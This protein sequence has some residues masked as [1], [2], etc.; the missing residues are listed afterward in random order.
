MIVLGIDPGATV[1]WAR[2][3]VSRDPVR[4]DIITYQ[5]AGDF[6]SD[7]ADH[8]A[9]KLFANVDIVGLEEAQ[10]AHGVEKF[11]AV[12][13]L[14][15]AR[16]I[17]ERLVTIAETKYGK[18][19]TRMTAARARGIVVGSSSPSD[20]TIKN[21]VLQRIRHWPTRSNAHQRDA[22]L[23]ALAVGQTTPVIRRTGT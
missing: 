15:A 2:L 11:Y 9:A 13:A 20:A 10:V 23:V 8:F 21:A 18:R 4:G 1:G 12:K 17:G 19:V 14:L 7:D 16:A 6:R 3:C 5:A 22:A